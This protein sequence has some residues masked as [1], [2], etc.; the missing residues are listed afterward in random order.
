MSKQ[1]TTIPELSTDPSP[2]DGI[3]RDALISPCGDYRYSLVR[4]WDKGKPYLPF[5]M[6]NPSTA[7]AT[8]DDPTIRRCMSFAR[9]EGCGGI[10]VVNLYALRSPDPKM[11]RAHYDP[12]GPFNK[13]VIYDAAIVAAEA[14]VPVVCA[15]GVND[16]T[17]AAGGALV[18]AREAGAA[19]KCLGKT[20]GGHPRHPLYVKSD[21]PLENYP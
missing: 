18:E 12:V 4:Q 11:L 6:L 17:Q 13:R 21:Q 9:R 2:S 19:I 7:D 3:Y 10:V 5:V 15:W 8:R 1:D 20:A 14:G 16:I